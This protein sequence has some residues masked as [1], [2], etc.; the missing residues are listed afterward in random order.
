MPGAYKTLV[1]GSQ[2][3]AEGYNYCGDNLGGLQLHVLGFRDRGITP[4]SAF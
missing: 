3:Q 4:A 1:E 2:S